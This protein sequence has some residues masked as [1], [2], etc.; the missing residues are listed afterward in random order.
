MKKTTA[1]GRVKEA[2]KLHADD[3]ESA[4]TTTKAN[5]GFSGDD[6]CP[7]KTAE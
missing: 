5:A 3:A 6:E 1:G 2:R 4:A 7:D